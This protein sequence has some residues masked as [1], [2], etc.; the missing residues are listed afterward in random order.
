MQE[1]T[2][3][4]RLNAAIKCQPVDQIPVAPKIEEYAGKLAGITNAEFLF[5][6]SK[7]LDALDNSWDVLGGWDMYRAVYIKL[8]GPLQKTIGI[9]RTRLPGR[10]LP[11]TAPY[12]AVEEEIMSADDYSYL[13]KTGFFGYSAEFW[14][15][16]HAVDDVQ[17]RDAIRLQSE[18]EN[19][20]NARA[21]AK[22]ML[23]LYGGFI[24]FALDFMALC[25]SLKG[26][27]LDLYRRPDVLERALQVVTD[28]IIGLAKQAAAGSGVP[29][30]F[31]GFTRGSG[32]FMSPAMFKRFVFPYLKLMVDALFPE[33]I[34]LFLHAD[35]DW[36]LHLEGFK[37]LPAHSVVLELDGTTD[38]VAAKRALAGHTCLLGDVSA[39]RLTLGASEEVGLYCKHL[40]R[41]IGEGGGFILGSGC[42]VPLTAKQENVETMLRSVRN[43]SID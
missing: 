12:Q 8:Y 28:E 1:M 23:P 32:V 15:R 42:T 26:F 36:T 11:D 21:R 18:L 39:T 9:T 19:E 31:V 6:R 7:A 34:V 22:G 16:A 10:E 43:H 35:S 30:I 3:E 5:D 25:R 41:E 20:C 37:E 29:R 38:I 40:I 24:P 13:F 14:R 33:G 4:D 27:V 2:L 17:I